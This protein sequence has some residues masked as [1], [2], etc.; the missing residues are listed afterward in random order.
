MPMLKKVVWED[1]PASGRY[2]LEVML[3]SLRERPGEWALVA[4]DYSRLGVVNLN[5]YHEDFE[6]V[7][8]GGT[9]NKTAKVYGRY[10]ASNKPGVAEDEL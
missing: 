6:F 2:D 1:P 4:T 3:Q 7:S 5:K 10:T 9:F 8:R